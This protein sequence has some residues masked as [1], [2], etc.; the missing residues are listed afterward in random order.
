MTACDFDMH[1][2]QDASRVRVVIDDGMMGLMAFISGPP[3]V[4]AA[5]YCRSCGALRIAAAQL[6]SLNLEEDRLRALA[7]NEETA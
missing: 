2:W 3:T 4:F 7:A 6:Q 5:D 1:E